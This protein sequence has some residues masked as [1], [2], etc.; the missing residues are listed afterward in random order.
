MTSPCTRNGNGEPVERFSLVVGGPFHGLLRRVGLTAEDSLPTRRAAVGLAL[1]VW[2]LPALAVAA[3]TLLADHYRGWDF[4]TDWTVYTRYLIAVCA[5]IAT[6]RYADGR[7]GLLTRHFR[8]ASL[9]ADDGV[10][11][12]KA[13]LAVADRRSSSLPAELII[14]VVALV[15]SGL[16]ETYTVDLAGS[17]WEGV[18]LG[19]DVALSWAGS[20]ARFFSTPFFLFLVLRWIWRFLVWSALL[21][22]ISR[23]PLRLTPVH[24]DR[25]GGLGFLSV[26]P[27]IFNGFVFALSCAVASGMLKELSLQSHAPQTVWL[28]LAGW[29]VF[30][31]LL[32]LGPLFA[33]VG[34]L[35]HARERALLEYGRLVSRHHL[36]FHRQWIEK[37][38]DAEEQAGSVDFS[39]VA[40]LN[41]IAEAVR[42]MRVVPIDLMVVLQVVV[43]AGAPLLTVV[44]TQIPLAQLVK[45]VVST[46][47]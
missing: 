37:V 5:M 7:I 29:L 26:F 6:E 24:P 28:A 19:G 17:N 1:L 30:C 12:F 20:V 36:T 3:Q 32:V 44:T 2:L 33:F 39:S 4:F 9:L 42:Q 46:V 45:W 18:D 35:Y 27:G 31:L 14:L 16:A 47:L 13:A 34:P 11:R 8:D 40:D 43:A 10:P 22:R 41:A 25:S 15:W 23:L 21:F 38:E